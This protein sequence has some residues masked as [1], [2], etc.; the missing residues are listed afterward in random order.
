M[1]LRDIAHHRAVPS[2]KDDIYL[3]SLD[4][5]NFTPDHDTVTSGLP[6]ESQ[7]GAAS[8]DDWDTAHKH[9][10]RA[11]AQYCAPLRGTVLQKRYLFFVFRRP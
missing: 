1:L 3:L 7:C 10:S 8:D 11:G 2:Y 5:P 9:D 4:G 6:S